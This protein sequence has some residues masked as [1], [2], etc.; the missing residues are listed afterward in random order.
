ML[1]KLL[2]ERSG[3]TGYHLEGDVID[4]P[5]EEALRMIRSR[6]AEP[7][8]PQSATRQPPAGPGRKPSRR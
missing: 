8:Q 2:T 5:D 3:Q 1:I 4:V 6:Q 7:V